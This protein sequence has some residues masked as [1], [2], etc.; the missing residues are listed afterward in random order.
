M[1]HGHQLKVLL[2]GAAGRIGSAFFHHARFGKL[3]LDELRRTPLPRTWV[4][5]G[6]ELLACCLQQALERL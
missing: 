2:T 1:D 6:C 3:G 4:N 5:K